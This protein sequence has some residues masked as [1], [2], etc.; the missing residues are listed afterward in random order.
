M[1]GWFWNTSRFFKNTFFYRTSPV[2]ASDIFRFPA[3]KFIKKETSAYIF[4]C[5]FCKIFKILFWQNPSGWLL[6]VFIYEF[7]EV[8][9][10]TS[11]MEHLWETA[12]LCTSCRI[13]TT[14]YTKKVFHK[15]FSRTKSSFSKV[16]IYL[17]FL[18]TTSKEVNL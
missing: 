2:A 6:L 18:K 10:I 12:Y 5:K 11:F 17:K 1:N 15:R 7:W 13:S 16:F 14:R 8:V 9:Q 3:C 4:F